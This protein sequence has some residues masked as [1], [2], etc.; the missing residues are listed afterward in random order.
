MAAYAGLLELDFDT[1]LMAQGHPIV[2][3]ARDARRRF[4]A[5]RAPEGTTA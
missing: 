5:E 3:G 1:L 4:V 2:R